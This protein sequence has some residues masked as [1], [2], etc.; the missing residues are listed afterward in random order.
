MVEKEGLKVEE[1]CVSIAWDWMYCGLT[2]NGINRE[3]LTVLEAAILNRKRARVSLAI[4]ELS[5]LRMAQFYAPPET[6]F[7][8]ASLIPGGGIVG[9]DERDRQIEVCRGILPG[10]RYVVRCHKEAMNMAS[11]EARETTE[12]AK[13]ISFCKLANTD[14][15][16]SESAM[17]PYGNGDFMCK[18]CSKELSNAY[19]HCD[20]CEKH[21]AKDF[22]I[23]FECHAQ[24][25]FR[26]T[27]Y[28]H[29]S[30][31]K[32]HAK[33]NHI[34]TSVPQF[35]LSFG[36]ALWKTRTLSFRVLTGVSVFDVFPMT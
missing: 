5:L 2:A 23:C 22:N 19:F 1:L 7:G 9:D 17:D 11:E 30:N 29:P 6:D 3:V 18:L 25:H 12:A 16:P 28:M 35:P 21:L 24:Q 26:K 32:R 13:R 20:G 31:V 34:G 15:A 33:L 14:E 36:G 8:L 4:P 10:L 27:I